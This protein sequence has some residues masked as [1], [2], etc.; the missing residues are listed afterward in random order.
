MHRKR[1]LSLQ[2]ASEISD[3]IIANIFS[4][5]KASPLRK[6]EVKGRDNSLLER[7]LKNAGETERSGKE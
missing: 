6:A 1:A 2:R 3:S 5:V 4:L 7:I